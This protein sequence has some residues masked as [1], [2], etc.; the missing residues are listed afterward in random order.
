MALAPALLRADPPPAIVELSPAPQPA[1]SPAPAPGPLALDLDHYRW[2]GVSGYAGKVTWKVHGAGI[3]TYATTDATT[4]L[5]A[6]QG[7]PGVT[8]QKVPAKAFIVWGVA[9]GAVKLTAWGVVDG[10]AIELDSKALA[11]GGA[12]PPTPVPGPPAPVPVPVDALFPALQAAYLAD[13]SPADCAGKL[14]AIYATAARSAVDDPTLKTLGDLLGD[15]KHAAA[16]LAPLPAGAKFREVLAGELDSK[17]G[18]NPAAP[19][20]SA[21]RANAKAQFARIATL[22]GGLK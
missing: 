12:V 15:L 19:L 22:L 5:G 4:V 10:E 16:A 8:P 14:A 7:T 20:D 1:P 13:G 18:T 11:V 3:G 21:A 6:L 9:P 17:L 2:F